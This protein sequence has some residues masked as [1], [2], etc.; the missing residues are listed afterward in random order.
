MTST[1][2]ADKIMN[3]SGDQ[4]SGVDLLVNDQVKLKTANTDRVIVDASGKVGIG[5]LNPASYNVHADELVVG[6]TDGNRGI[7]I[8]GGDDDYSILNLNRY[9][10]TSTTPNGAIEYNHTDNQMYIKAGGNHGVQINSNGTVNK[11]NNPYFFG[12]RSAGQTGAGAIFISNVVQT[13]TGTHY[14]TS[15]GRFTAPVAGRYLCHFKTFSS[16]QGLTN[17]HYNAQLRINNSPISRFYFYHSGT[18]FPINWSVIVELNA[19]DY[20]THYLAGNLTVYGT[21]WHYAQQGFYLIG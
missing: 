11:P 2:H 17:G 5:I 9:S 16:P 4:D 1:I 21:D 14:D 18:H 20:V 12:G 6:G 8:V 19:S 13:N 10:N 3:S 15:N 7:T